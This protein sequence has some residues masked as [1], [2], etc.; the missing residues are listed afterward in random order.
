MVYNNVR[1]VTNFLAEGR[2]CKMRNAH[3]QCPPEIICS[4]MQKWH[5]PYARRAPSIDQKTLC[6]RYFGVIPKISVW[7]V[8]YK[9]VH[10]LWTIHMLYC[11]NI[12][13]VKMRNL[14]EGGITMSRTC[15]YILF[16]VIGFWIRIKEGW[17]GS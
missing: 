9:A 1:K 10:G 15:S 14:T 17:S 16:A 3:I 11:L 8:D 4:T 6:G 13:T 12:Q 7:L 2:L 5:H